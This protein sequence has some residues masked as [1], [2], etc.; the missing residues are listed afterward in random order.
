[1][2][3]DKNTLRKNSSTTNQSQKTRNNKTEKKS[4]YQQKKKTKSTTRNRRTRNPRMQINLPR[5][6]FIQTFYVRLAHPD[7]D[8]Q[9]IIF[10]LYPM[11]DQESN[12]YN[13]ILFVTE[14]SRNNTISKDALKDLKLKSHDGSPLECP[15][16]LSDV[17]KRERVRVLPCKHE[18]HSRCVD[19]WL[20]MQEDCCPICRKR[21]TIM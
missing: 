2:P 6:H 21:V 16:C 8:I 18:F 13:I 7:Y 17:Q 5:R 11:F 14:N 10:S 3:T 12:I 4:N 9:S 20:K 19:K 1:M 15:I